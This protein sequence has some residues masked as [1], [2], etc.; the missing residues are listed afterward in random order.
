MNHTATMPPVVLHRCDRFVARTMNWLYDH[1][2]F[3]PDVRQLVLCDSLQNRDE[4][5]EL[6]AWCLNPH[7][8]ARRLWRK[9]AGHRPYI[10]D[11]MRL[12]ARHPRVLHSHFG[13]VGVEDFTLQEALGIPWLVGFYGADVYQLG[14]HSE[15]Q[16]TYQ[17]LFE[18]V[19][20]A[21]ALGP[22]M[23]ER[24]QKLGCLSEKVKV[25]PL[26][27]E[28][29][30]LPFQP[31]VLKP[32][33]PLR[34]L[35]AGTFR[36]K[37]GIQYVLDG[38]ALAHRRG[39]KLHL[40]LVAGEMGKSG[41]EETRDAAF[42]TIR[43]L[44]IEHVVTYSPLLPFQKL[45]RLSLHCHLFLT[46][47]VTAANGDCEGTPFVL[48]Q[49]MA[50]GMPAIATVHSDIPFIFGEL[51]HLLVPERDS[52]AI[53]DRLQYYAENPERVVSDGVAMRNRIRSAF[54]VRHCASQLA[55]IYGSLIT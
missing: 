17:R 27:V 8:V 15:W 49:M 36:E 23:A 45:L 3:V 43:R 53:A 14:L 52:N 6:E 46:P 34:L 25:H 4:F 5:P 21:L 50:T 1:L 31:R 24:L 40:D 55:G 30:A 19:S 7:S 16:E 9:L 13:Y 18:R 51:K 33:E 10:V 20:F 47:S 35:F 39:V 26:G 28:V 32:G 2:R 48:Q 12:K 37:K 41:E 22:V 42:A 11:L 29:E 44:G 38:V 54:D